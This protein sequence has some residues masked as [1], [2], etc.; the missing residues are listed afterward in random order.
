M[1]LL[2]LLQNH[3]QL[4]VFDYLVLPRDRGLFSELESPLRLRLVYCEATSTGVLLVHYAP[5]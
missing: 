3:G 1:L 2:G 5:A 4:A